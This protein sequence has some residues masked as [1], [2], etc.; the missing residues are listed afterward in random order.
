MS[1]IEREMTNIHVAANKLR[2]DESIGTFFGIP[3]VINDWIDWKRV[4]N[5]IVTNPFT[6]DFA[7]FRRASESRFVTLKNGKILYLKLI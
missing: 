4:D 5:V 6:G 7:T 1:S 3:K 2:W